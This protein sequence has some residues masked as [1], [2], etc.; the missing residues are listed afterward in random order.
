MFIHV[1][2][3][4][5]TWSSYT[6]LRATAGQQTISDQLCRMSDRFCEIVKYHFDIISGQLSWLIVSTVYLYIRN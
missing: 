1:A 6:E 4:N 2:I 5:F 3:Q